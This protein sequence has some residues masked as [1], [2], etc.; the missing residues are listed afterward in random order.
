MK[1]IE[2]ENCFLIEDFFGPK[3][4]AG[5]S[6]PVLSGNSE[7]DLPQIIEPFLKKFKIASLEQIHSPQI[8]NVSK[9]GKYI[10]DG[11]IT[12]ENNL[13][14]VVKTA[15]CFPILFYS[16][17]L[18]II[19]A[20]HM[21]WRGAKEGILDNIKYDLN[22]FKVV[23]GVGM[24]KCCYR[25][26][27]EFMDYAEFKGFVKKDKDDLYFNPIEFIKKSFIA[28]GLKDTN[29]LDLGICSIC[30][31]L[32]LFS[33]RKNATDNRTLSFIVKR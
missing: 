18:N 31:G 22:S 15:D 9:E 3:I 33:F 2:K 7:E 23:A 20:V 10:G 28:R 6:K 13:V 5:F 26:G 14:C 8:H 12:Q 4:L 17:K 16:E 19:G 32:N 29:F 30:S 1:L 21:G 25:V 24:R 11:L 27:V